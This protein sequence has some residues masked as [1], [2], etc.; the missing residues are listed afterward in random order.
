M[1]RFDRYFLYQLTVLFGFFSLVLVSVYWINRAVILFDQLLADGQSAGVFLTLTLYTL[2][3]VIRMVLPISAFVAAVYVTNRLTTESELVVAQATGMS[4]WRMARPVF[5]FGLLVCVLMMVLVH[6]LVPMSRT[7]LAERSEEIEANVAARMLTEGQFLHPAKGIT[8]YIREITREGELNDVFLADARADTTR[9]DYMATRA[10]LVQ[11]GGAP[12]LVMVDGSAQT[13]QREDGRLLVTTF[14]SFT[15][16]VG[17][18]MENSGRTRTDVREY[19]TLTLFSPD[20]AALDA[21][22]RDP[23]NFYYEGH[24]RIAQPLNPLIAALIGFSALMVGSFSRFGVWKQIGVAVVLIIVLQAIENGTADVARSDA[25]LW[26]LIYLPTILGLVI[27]ATL[28]WLAGR[29]ALFKRV[30]RANA[31]DVAPGTAGVAT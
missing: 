22:R 24:L 15:Y 17:A 12:K 2:P 25:S 19:D 7:Q 26:P 14:D 1:A 10:Y 13:Y 5:L 31:S 27:V 4:P 21:T 9:T 20:Q 11:E 3:N 16:D 28:L 18:L 29:P 30:P 8:F 23:S 6:F